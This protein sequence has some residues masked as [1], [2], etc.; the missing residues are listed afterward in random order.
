MN[1]AMCFSP[2][3][4]PCYN[5]DETGFDGVKLRYKSCKVEK[6]IVPLWRLCHNS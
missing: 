6:L 1:N 3:Y 2:L 5:W 4:R